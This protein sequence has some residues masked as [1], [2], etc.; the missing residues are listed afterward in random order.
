MFRK[1]NFNFKLF[2]SHKCHGKNIGAKISHQIGTIFFGRQ[3]GKNFVFK[4]QLR[5]LFVFIYFKII[6]INNQRLV[7]NYKTEQFISFQKKEINVNKHI[8][9]K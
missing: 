7:N 6:I 2:F 9:I 4:C 5:F 8:I 3:F 1:T